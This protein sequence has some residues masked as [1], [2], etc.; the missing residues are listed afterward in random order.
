MMKYWGLLWQV[1]VVTGNYYS[2]DL[3]WTYYNQYIAFKYP[4][5]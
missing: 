1:A 5:K 2:P 4:I 3:A